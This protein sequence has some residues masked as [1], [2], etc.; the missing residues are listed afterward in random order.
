MNFISVA[1]V[2]PSY[3][4]AILCCMLGTI[5]AFAAF[6]YQSASSKFERFLYCLWSNAIFKLSFSFFASLFVL[7]VSMS[8]LIPAN[9]LVENVSKSIS[10]V[11]AT[12][13][14]FLFKVLPQYLFYDVVIPFIQCAIVIHWNMVVHL[15]NV[16]SII[17]KY[18]YQ[19]S[20]IWSEWILQTFVV[21]VMNVLSSVVLTMVTIPIITFRLL[22]D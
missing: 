22:F 16:G 18:V 13:F 10:I 14:V 1:D 15:F 20:L 2:P 6:D 3:A 5:L 12:P 4:I 11:G 7:G 17:L 9:L 21:P 8:V 19:S